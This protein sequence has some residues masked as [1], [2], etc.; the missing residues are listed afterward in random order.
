MIIIICIALIYNLRL[1]WLMLGIGIIVISLSVT[2]K[3]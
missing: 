3:R 2:V 1:N